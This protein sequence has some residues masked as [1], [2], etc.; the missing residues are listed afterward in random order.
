M[1][2]YLTHELEKNSKQQK[3]KDILI[4]ASALWS[5]VESTIYI[6]RHYS[7][8]NIHI[9]FRDEDINNLKPET[10]S[11]L[12]EIPYSAY[13]LDFSSFFKI[14]KINPQLIIM[15]CDNAYNIGYRKA[16]F[17][18]LICKTKLVIFSNILNEIKYYNFSELWRNKG[19]YI[20]NLL[21]ISLD[22]ITAPIFFISFVGTVYVIKLF[23]RK[24]LPLPEGKDEAKSIK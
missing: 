4:F 15:L 3:I 21:I 16:K 7:N 13:R 9:F 5:Q 12:K 11:I 18:S 22:L 8:A 23:N 14:K 2:A 1:I 20:R 17:F 19:Q 10:L 6:L 24:P